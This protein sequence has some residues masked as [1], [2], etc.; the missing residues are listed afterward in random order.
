MARRNDWN[1][2]HSFLLVFGIGI[3]TSTS[4]HAQ[5]DIH[6]KK[7]TDDVV[8]LRKAKSSQEAL[9]KTVISWSASG[10]P[11]I[12]LMDEIK[13][14]EDNEFRSIG[15][16]KFK[17]NQI[18]TYVY[19]RQNTGLVSKGDYFHSNEQDI[20]YSAIEKN[21]KKGCTVSYTI[22]GHVGEQEFVFLSYNPKAKFS[23][24][25]NGNPAKPVIGKSGV[26]WV[27]LP[28]IRKGEKISFSITNES[29][30]NE[31]FVILNHNPQK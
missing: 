28:K 31:S 10:N 16:N 25:V 11:K 19:D 4:G 18:V 9:N 26:R 21:V 12:T 20:Y 17:M 1:M 24:I 8:Q 27:K 22:K 7:M 13:R 5:E 15:S 23:A 30:S 3:L 2:K 29:D 6:L 14:D